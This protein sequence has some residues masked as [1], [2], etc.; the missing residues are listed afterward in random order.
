M[1]KKGTPS[2]SSE[3][4]FSASRFERLPSK[5]FPKFFKNHT[6]LHLSIYNL[7]RAKAKRWVAS[8]QQ[9]KLLLWWRLNQ[10]ATMG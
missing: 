2:Y 6:T 3:N 1:Y 8:H 7:K 4:P 9:A 5:N 10:E